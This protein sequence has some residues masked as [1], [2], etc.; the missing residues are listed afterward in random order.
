MSDHPPS[1]LLEEL[2][3]GVADESTK[4]HVDRCDACAAYVERLREGAAEF[5]DQGPTAFEFADQVAARTGAPGRGMWVGGAALALVAAAAAT[6]FLVRPADEPM[7]PVAMAPSATETAGSP[8]TRFKGAPQL[9]VIRQRDGGQERLSAE[10]GVRAWDG[11]R[12]EVSVDAPTMLEVGVLSDDRT[13]V[14]LL[15]AKMLSPGTHLTPQ[16]LRFD[17]EPGDAWIIAGPPEAVERARKS[18][19]FEGVRVLP[20]HVETER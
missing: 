14:T 19:S 17:N 11:F 3:A 12:V 2:A 6:F 20:L 1:Y 13:W 9:A 8:S 4:R 16:A 18:R 10:A 7:G 15:P 5:A